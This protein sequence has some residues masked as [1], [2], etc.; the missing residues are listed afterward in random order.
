M[1]YLNLCT[2]ELRL[3]PR[4]VVRTPTGPFYLSQLSDGERRL[5]SLFVDIA[6]QL[7]LQNASDEILSARAI[8]LIDEIDVHLH[9]KWQPLN[10]A[11]AP[12]AVFETFHASR[13]TYGSPRIRACLQRQGCHH[14]KAPVPNETLEN[15]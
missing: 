6:R 14:G 1:G 2:I 11:P 4:I 5:F 8:V 13:A 15:L 9:P 7:S 10:S 3:T 12:P